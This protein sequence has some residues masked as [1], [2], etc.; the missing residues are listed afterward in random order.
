MRL[1]S[2]ISLSM[3]LGA[4]VYGIQVQWE[5]GNGGNGHF[6]EVVSDTAASWNQASD[7]AV[8][9]G[10]HLATITSAAEQ[11]FVE[12]LLINQGSPTGAY[13]I[14]LTETATEGE[15]VWGTG[16]PLVYTYWLSGEPNNGWGDEDS[17]S[18]LWTSD[19]DSNL[20]GF[21]HRGYWNDLHHLGRAP[22]ED[23]LAPDLDR[24]GYVVEII[25]EP[26]CLLL[27]VLGSLTVSR[28]KR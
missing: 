27:I 22:G 13:W 16:E 21:S 9:K 12:N 15:Y 18:I 3:V 25:P 7:S 10:G 2:A 6:Y 8:I 24:A 17:G 14:G 26:S 23:P 20:P 5:V 28:R 4:S 11:Q 1:V 19:A